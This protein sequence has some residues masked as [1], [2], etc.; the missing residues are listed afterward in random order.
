M[1]KIKDINR[2]QHELMDLFSDQDI[3]SQIVEIT[4]QRN[5]K[6]RWFSIYNSILGE[7]IMVKVNNKTL[8]AKKI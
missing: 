2:I 3:F 5:K 7:K 4:E 1:A 6:Y 8:E